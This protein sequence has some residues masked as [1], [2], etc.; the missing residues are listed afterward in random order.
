LDRF[1]EVSQ[2]FPHFV[3]Q[4][5]EREVKSPCFY[6][7]WWALNAPNNTNSN[8]N[9]VDDNNSNDIPVSMDCEHE[10]TICNSLFQTNKQDKY[11]CERCTKS[12][13]IQREWIAS[14]NSLS[15][16]AERMISRSN[17][18]LR[19]IDIGDN[20][21]ILIPHVNS[22]RGDPRDILCIVTHFRSYTE[23]YK[24]GTRHRLLNSTFSRNQF[25]P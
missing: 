20:V 7:V 4:S 5:R 18:I 21:T 25:M 19:P 24:L 12:N 6:Y 13:H 15:K 23:Q 22:G 1:S 2:I 17:Q 8:V 9:S 10:C 16:Q 11:T 14:G 3:L